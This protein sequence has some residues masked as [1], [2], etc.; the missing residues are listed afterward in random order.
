MLKHFLLSI[1]EFF[2]EFLWIENFFSEENAKKQ[3]EIILKNEFFTHFWKYWKIK[4]F[5]IAF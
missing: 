2:C 1:S 5:I 3:N 4:I